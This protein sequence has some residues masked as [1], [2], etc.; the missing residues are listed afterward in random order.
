MKKIAF[1]LT[2]FVFCMITVSCA[3]APKTAEQIEQMT[4]DIEGY[5]LPIQLT[6]STAVVYVIRAKRTYGAWIPF[7]VSIDDS[8]KEKLSNASIIAYVIQPGEHTLTVK[9]ENTKQIP[10]TADAGQVYF[11]DVQPRMGFFYARVNV[12]SMDDVEGVYQV[13]HLYDEEKS[14]V[15][16]VE[17]NP[18]P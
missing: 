4:Q 13:K 14:I 5:Q 3:S 17:P 9:G 8:S 12:E 10:F 1:L 16:N 15:V 11:F 7:K 18:Q 2:L 6:R